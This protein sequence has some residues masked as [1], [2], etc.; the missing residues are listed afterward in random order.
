MKRCLVLSAGGYLAHTIVRLAGESQLDVLYLEPKDILK[1][2]WHVANAPDYQIKIAVRGQMICFTAH[3]LFYEDCMSSLSAYITDHYQHASSYHQH[4]WQAFLVALYQL[5]TPLLSFQPQHFSPY[6]WLWPA[7]MY[8]ARS[9]RIKTIEQSTY[10]NLIPHHHTWVRK[11]YWQQCHWRVGQLM[12]VI[13]I[14]DQFSLQ[15]TDRNRVWR[16]PKNL[17]NKCRL[18]AKSCQLPSCEWYF[19]KSN[20]WTLLGIYHWQG[21]GARMTPFLKTWLSQWF[22]IQQPQVKSTLSAE[23]LPDINIWI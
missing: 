12:R 2:E 21:Q 22:T 20:T 15:V 1:S 7:M 18:L 23:D 8:R 13:Q 11:E 9:Y 4:S 16:M 10:M 6:F 3:D 19:V 5:L 17:Q 14:G